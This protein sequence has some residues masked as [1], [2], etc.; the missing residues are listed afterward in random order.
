MK[1]LLIFVILLI[2]LRAEAQQ[3]KREFTIENNLPVNMGIQ[4]IPNGGHQLNERVRQT[5]TKESSLKIKLPSNRDYRIRPDIFVSNTTE[6]PNPTP[7][8][9]FPICYYEQNERF[10]ELI[11]NSTYALNQRCEIKE[12]Y[13]QSGPPR[14][15]CFCSVNITK[16]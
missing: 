6:G 8:P 10:I 15:A 7:T 13:P 14:K 1:K 11:P 3:D 12:Y 5:I 9:E 2:S 16:S 4:A